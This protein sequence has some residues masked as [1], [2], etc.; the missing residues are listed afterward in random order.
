MQTLLELS[1]CLTQNKILSEK[2]SGSSKVTIQIWPKLIVLL[3]AFLI[4]KI[5]RC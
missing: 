2:L 4:F 5:K 1:S 3:M